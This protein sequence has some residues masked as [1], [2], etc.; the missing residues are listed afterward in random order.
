MSKFKHDVMLRVV[1]ILDVLMITLPF[2]ACWLMYYEA[3]TPMHGMWQG[4]V[5]ILGLFAVLF[6]LLGKTYDAFWM[7]MQRISELIYGQILAPNPI[8]KT[9]E[10][11][12]LFHI[13]INW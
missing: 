4:H 10:F 1:K 11:L 7:S 13:S 3:Y 5:V 9:L 2:A 6:V 8:I 12:I